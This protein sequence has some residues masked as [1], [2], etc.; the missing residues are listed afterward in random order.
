MRG[1]LFILL[2]AVFLI[3]FT[4]AVNCIPSS[5]S[6]FYDFGDSHTTNVYCT[7]SGN[8]TTISISGD[9]ISTTETNFNIGSKTIPIDFSS[10]S[11]AGIHSG[12]LNFGDG[13][14]VPISF[15]VEGETQTQE[16]DILVFPTSKVITVK[17]GDEKVQN[18]LITVPQDY[19]RTITIQ[20][21]DFNPGVETIQ[22]GDLNLGQVSP[23]QSIQIP[24]L[25]SGIEA[26]TGSYQTQLNIFAVDS[27]GQ[28]TIPTINLQLQIS[29]GINPSV[30]FSLN[31]LPVCSLN[32]G[33]LNLNSTYSLT[34]T[35]N[36][37]NINIRPVIDYFYVRGV[38][39]EETSSQYIY[40]FKALKIGNTD[41]IADFL[42]KNAPIGERFSQEVRIS[43]SGSSPIPGT[44][45][46]VIFY[47]NSINVDME[48]LG[49]GS[50][51]LIIVDNSTKSIVGSYSLLLN[52]EQT[53]NTLD[54]KS[55]TLYELRIS[56]PGYLD[57]TLNF[58]VSQTPITLTLNP[59][60][61]FYSL[62]EEIN[63][64]TNVN[65][66]LLLDGV[67]INSPYTLNSVGTFL[68]KAVKQGYLTK[69]INLTVNDI[70]YIVSSTPLIGEWKK[71][72]NV[73]AELNENAS[74]SILFY[75]SYKEDGGVWYNPP[76]TISSGS[77]KLIEFKIKDFGKYEIKDGE[78]V[79][80]TKI[81]ERK[82]FSFFSDL[83]WYWWVLIVI[84][85]IAVLIIIA[86]SS[87]SSDEFT[88][89]PVFSGGN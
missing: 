1:K 69:E 79:I 54:L 60:K 17:Q 30:N 86:R 70:K 27:E 7:N 87:S 58:N 56:S 41:I 11:P 74:W 67:V 46:D 25:F 51:T 78:K 48:N 39:V 77:G 68:L 23:G 43:P 85:I 88:E 2:L 36:N 9:Y 3:G 14:S 62:G 89:T 40:N 84:V 19:P 82:S 26:S 13:S 33:D 83:E 75:E 4:Q 6:T 22:F 37:A 24:I 50:T 66:S 12:F 81:I 80:Q 16:G 10:S 53:N 52:G 49:E 73:V 8:S 64:T 35:R 57:R 34:C 45:L 32:A 61:E 63:I 42:Y 5:I 18:I 21:V 29:S 20:S 76:E 31:E 71:G 15:I 44:V 55:D 65:A 28:V 47:Q 59:N 38:S 72:K